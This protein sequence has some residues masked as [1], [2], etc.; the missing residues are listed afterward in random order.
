[1]QNKTMRA[2]LQAGEALTFPPSFP[3]LSMQV[4][5]AMWQVPRVPRV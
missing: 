1:M 3:S 5:A 2:M 4:L